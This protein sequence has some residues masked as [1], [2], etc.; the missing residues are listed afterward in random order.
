MF[1]E[2]S[3]IKLCYKQYRFYFTFLYRRHNAIDWSFLCPL[4]A[5]C[6][7]REIA[8]YEQQNVAGPKKKRKKKKKEKGEISKCT[9]ENK[10]GLLAGW[11]WLMSR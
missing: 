3:F 1:S 4:R 2:Q 5:S 6:R 9:S 11:L 10:V 7:R 8:K